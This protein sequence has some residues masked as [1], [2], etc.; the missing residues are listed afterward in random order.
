MSKHEINKLRSDLEQAQSE[1]SENR[2][3]GDLQAAFF[4]SGG[5]TNTS[6]DGTFELYANMFWS[7]VRSRVK[8]DSRIGKTVVIDPVTGRNSVMGLDDL[9]NEVRGGELSVLFSDHP[10]RV[11]SSK[12]S[13]EQTQSSGTV[14]QHD[15]K[16]LQ[17]MTPE[18][19]MSYARASANQK[20]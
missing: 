19:K 1:A 8:Y 10:E 17:A 9:I 7:Q 18:Q 20:R 3:R 14:P 5:K 2:A 12:Q 6:G 13:I 16:A 15:L 4:F 11:A